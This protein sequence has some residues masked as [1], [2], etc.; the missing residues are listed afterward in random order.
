M[1]GLIRLSCW[2]NLGILWW[3]FNALSL[4]DAP[5]DNRLRLIIETD[6]G[7]DPD[8]EQSLVRFLLYANE[9][10]IE[11]IIANRPDTRRPENNNPEPTGLGV[12]RRLVN[13]YGLCYSNLLRHDP[14]YPKPDVLLARTVAGYDDIDDAVKL[15][16]ATADRS[17]PRPI[18]Y[19]DWGTNHGSAVNNLKRAL[20]RVLKERGPKGYAAF[21]TQLRVICHGNPFGDH[22]T[23]LEP[24]FPLLVDTFRPAL[25]GKR[26]YH[27]FSALTATAGGFDLKRDVLSGHGPLGAIYPTNT[28]H[29]QKEGDSMTFLYLVPTGLGDPEH[30]EWGSWAGRYGPNPEFKGRR[31]FWANQADTWQGSTHRDNTL[32]RWAVDLQNDFRVRLEW[33][34]KPPKE[35]NH[36]PRLVVNGIE[37]TDAIRLLPPAGSELKLDAKGSSDSDGDRLSYAWFVYPDAGT[38]SGAVTIDGA[39]S[40]AATVHVPADAAGKEIHVLLGVTDSGQPPLTRYRRVVINPRDPAG[41][42]QTIAPFFQPPPEFAGKLGSYRSPLLFNDGTC[43]QSPA[44]W[45]RRHKEIMDTWHGLMGPW[46]AVLEKPKVEILAHSRRDNFTQYRVRLEI[47]P[48]QTGEGWLMVPEGSGPFPAV[49][50]V[51]YEPETSAGLNPKEPLRDFGLQLARRGFVTLSVGTPGGD[52]RKPEIG[53]A[54]CQPLSFHAYV[55]ANCCQALASRPE[56]DAKRIGVVGHS[57]GGKWALFAAALWE[58]FTCVAVSDPGIVFDETRPNVNYWEPWYLG[59]DPE[60]PRPKPGIPS[61]DNPRTGAYRKMVGAGRDLPELHALIA[62]RPFL[63]SGGS[64]D[65]PSRWLALNH[66]VAVNKLL[67]QSN[68]VAMTNRKGH[69]PS[70]ESNAQLYAFFEHFLLN[71]DSRGRK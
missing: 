70:E 27:R 1:K 71:G 37:G 48:E 5:K 64:E 39:A 43:V 25:E 14:R 4:A 44:D 68:R 13:A 35:A 28:T 29:P 3:S 38:Y 36:P 7:G 8:D 52:A 65:P 17:D 33:C 69:P 40:S 10:D 16:I 32:K 15:I 2:L 47:A 26:W 21:K 12:V 6:A 60:H 11:G 51:Y 67:G 50:V 22:A 9:W 61:D 45:P 66:A 55:A 53:K 34:V 59:F 58:R 54:H 57:Y 19:A 30:P 46:P 62:P 24:P 49:L 23:R 31:C 41:A 18:W 42:W 56:V 63:V 20:D